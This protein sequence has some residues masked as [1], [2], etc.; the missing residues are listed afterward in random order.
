MVKSEAS[1]LLKPEWLLSTFKTKTQVFLS[2]PSPD[3][4]LLLLFLPPTPSLLFISPQPHWPCCNF[5]NTP[6][7]LL[8]RPFLRDPLL[9]PP[10]HLF[11]LLVCLNVTSSWRCSLHAPQAITLLTCSRCTLYFSLLTLCRYLDHYF[12]MSLSLKTVIFLAAKSVLI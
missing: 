4:L 11:P 8:L 5:W 3:H 9:P 12:L 10:C 7:F 1:F 6:S 2:P